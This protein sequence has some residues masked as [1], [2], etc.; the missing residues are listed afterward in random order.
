MKTQE[1]VLRILGNS[2]FLAAQI[3]LNGLLQYLFF[4]YLTYTIPPEDLSIFELGRTCLEIGTGVIAP[5]LVL[6]IIRENARNHQW[7]IIH[8]KKIKHFHF[9]LFLVVGGIFYVLGNLESVRFLKLAV[10]GIL[11]GAIYHHTLC[12]IYEA[13][14]LSF[15]RVR[16]PILINILCNTLSI[17]IGI[18]SVML[19]PYPLIGVAVSLLIRWMLTYMFLHV[20]TN[21]TYPEIAGDTDIKPFR[22][23]ELMT[24]YWPLT[25][26]S[27][28][29]IMYA[30]IDVL[31]L[32][33]LGHADSIAIYGGAY[34]P[35][36]LISGIFLS[37][38]QA[39]SPS[40]SRQ[41][42]HSRRKTFKFVSMVGIG[43]FFVGLFITI[44]IQYFSSSI[45]SIYPDTYLDSRACLL[46]LSWTMPIIFL[47]NAFGYYL[48]NEETYGVY[49][50]AGISIL[51]L[52]INV[53][54]NFLLIPIHGFI[55]AA[56][57]TVA[58]DATTTLA[59]LVFSAIIAIRSK[60]ELV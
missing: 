33:W 37:V 5:G 20:L 30:R 1:S 3:V 12:N 46:A 22:I 60:K 28:S 9:Y 55:G 49:Y 47:G 15:E 7:W 21:E 8:K 25:L 50:Y 51:G 24:M 34:R 2:G 11:C 44:V 41:L 27:I 18:L 10:I 6:I 29:F 31:M 38:Y 42:R 52:A 45:V 43:F 14:F 17:L 26:G 58:T 48:V 16:V 56:W 57:M 36:N 35:I 23:V 19:L 40:I 53:T 54:G 4:V 13:I 32:D 59:M 39:L